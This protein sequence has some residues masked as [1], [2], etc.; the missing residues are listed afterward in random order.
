MIEVLGASACQ[1]CCQLS[2]IMRDQRVRPVAF[3]TER[4]ETLPGSDYLADG[5]IEVSAL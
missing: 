5:V 4:I 2:E 1:F 3:C